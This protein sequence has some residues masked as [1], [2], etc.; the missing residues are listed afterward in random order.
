MEDFFC[1]LLETML[2]P[3]FLSALVIAGTAGLSAFKISRELR[4]KAIL[5]GI[6]EKTKQIHDANKK[7][8]EYSSLKFIEL[9]SVSKSLKN[10]GNN[11]ETSDLKESAN[12]ITEELLKHSLGSSQ[13]VETLCAMLYNTITKIE[14]TENYIETMR[15]LSILTEGLK[16]IQEVAS[17]TIEAPREIK[18]ENRRSIKKNLTPYLKG[19][20][21]KTSPDIKLGAI[22]QETRE[23]A[24]LFFSR[25]IYTKLNN[26]NLPVYQDFFELIGGNHPI[27]LTMISKNI[28][29][30]STIIFEST[31][32]LADETDFHA[33]YIN[34]SKT[35]DGAE[36]REEVKI[37][38]GNI[39]PFIKT[40]LKNLKKENLL[41]KIEIPKNHGHSIS[42][43]NIK[44]VK[45]IGEYHIEL[46][47][48]AIDGK[49]N[50]KR[51]RREIELHLLESSGNLTFLRRTK[52]YLLNFF[53]FKS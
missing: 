11:K 48:L 1:R 22:L 13:Q 14:K 38:Y 36:K 26:R 12:L 2:T 6:T 35:I 45:A 21:Y 53:R 37:I 49:K 46:T 3:E 17:S 16:I 30:P 23:E 40:S 43:T 20:G 33:V 25:C 7:V 4:Y 44:N 27:K 15:T 47:F 10:H 34:F 24:L 5:D 32:A 8:S 52:T 31:C 50:Y 28:F 41:E 19:E 39:S 18:L 29:L 51:N 9:L 42:K